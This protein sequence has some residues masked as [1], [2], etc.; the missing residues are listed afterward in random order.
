VFEMG[1]TFLELYVAQTD[2]DRRRVLLQESEVARLLREGHARPVR[3]RR[4]FVRR[5]VVGLG[6]RLVAWGAR[7]QA[8]YGGWDLPRAIPCE[9]GLD[10]VSRTM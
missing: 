10:C 5:L 9:P 8:R 1:H 6:E 4:A 3:R 7:L 2:A